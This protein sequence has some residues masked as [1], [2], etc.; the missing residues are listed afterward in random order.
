MSLL[1]TKLE[2][3]VRLR[4]PERIFSKQ[5]KIPSFVSSCGGILNGDDKQE[6]GGSWV[7]TYKDQK[8]GK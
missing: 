2:L 1:L 6:R 4:A 3:S 5:R 8:K 7:P